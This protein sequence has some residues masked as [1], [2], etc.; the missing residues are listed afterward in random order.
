[1]GGSSAASDWIQ[2]DDTLYVSYAS[3][4]LE[5]RAVTERS[6]ELCYMFLRFINDSKSTEELSGMILNHL[7]RE[8]YQELL[9]ELEK[10]AKPPLDAAGELKI[11]DSEGEKR[12][13]G[14][15]NSHFFRDAFKAMTGDTIQMR[16]MME[17]HI[18]VTMKPLLL[19]DGTDNI[20][21]IMPMRVG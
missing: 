2:W 16:Y 9:S 14:R 1:M 11:L 19:E 13:A 6:I 4:I 17:D 12:F 3:D 7:P 5:T 20:H 8:E 10:R 15:L 18:K 21:I